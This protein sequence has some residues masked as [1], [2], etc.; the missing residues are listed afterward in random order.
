MIALAFGGTI[1]AFNGKPLGFEPPEPDPEYPFLRFRFDDPDFNPAEYEDYNDA[2]Y[3]S[4]WRRRDDYE[5]NVWDFIDESRRIGWELSF[6]EYKPEDV[7]FEIIKGRTNGLSVKSSNRL[8]F[9]GNDHLT[10]VRGLVIRGDGNE[11]PSLYCA[12]SNCRNLV[13]VELLDCSDIEEADFMF[14]D[15]ESL[16][17][18]SMPSIGNAT[19]LKSMFAGTKIVEAPFFDTS[20]VRNAIG[21]F[22]GCDELVYAPSYDF[23]SLVYGGGMFAY[24]YKLE[25]ANIKTSNILGTEDSLVQAGARKMF[26]DCR[27]LIEAPSEL[28]L[29]SAT[30]IS[31]IFTNCS[32]LTRIPAYNLSSV[33]DA[34]QAFYGCSGLEAI[35]EFDLHSAEDMNLMF[36]DCSSLTEVP[37]FDFSSAKNTSSM[38]S[39]CSGLTRIPAFV[40]PSTLEDAGMM[41]YECSS[42]QELPSGLDISMIDDVDRMFSYCT[43]LTT[44]PTFTFKNG[45]S[46]NG[47]FSY[48]TSLLSFPSDYDFSHVSEA[49]A[50]FAGMRSITS[51]PVEVIETALHLT[52]LPYMF[53]DCVSLALIP[54][55]DTSRLEN[56]TRMFKGCPIESLPN[57]NFTS[58]KYASDMFFEC[59]SLKDVSNLTF[60]SA[61]EYIPGMFASCYEIDSLSKLPS[62]LDISNATDI[63]HLFYMTKIPEMPNWDYSHITDMSY[64]FHKTEI[65]SIRDINVSSVVNVA[66][67]FEDCDKV[68]SGILNMYEKLSNLGSQIEDHEWCFNNCGDTS[69]QSVEDELA[70]IPSDWK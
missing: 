6:S 29:D 34:S 8:L 25:S 70:Q 20:N 44:I 15:S 22:M 4:Y 31:C 50:M 56:V 57:F 61:L 42:L 48:C 37:N 55:F 46:V 36:G 16:T 30:D 28:V 33:V 2:H 58:A 40:F 23:S 38:F 21:M 19:D 27:S 66:H 12:F 45:A 11:H 13:S 63:N 49:D 3:W 62:G 41:F 35:P 14:E 54:L 68:Q 65:T 59:Q 9:Y 53:D 24:C 69:I 5:G 52:S 67:T 43:S 47:I 39:G 32:S 26:E 10:A 60:S 7:N 18:V 17:S 64:T 51:V 1:L